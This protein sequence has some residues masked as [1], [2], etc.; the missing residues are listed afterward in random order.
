M[1]SFER[2]IWAF[3]EE[4]LP[5]RCCSPGFA[6]EDD[7]WQCKQGPAWQVVDEIPDLAQPH[8]FSVCDG[9]C[10]NPTHNKSNLQLAYA[11]FNGVGWGDL[12]QMWMD[13]E[14]ATLSD[15][16]RTRRDAEAEAKRQEEERQSELE[17]QSRIITNK[18][19]DHAIWAGCKD[20]KGKTMAIPCKFLYDCQKDGKTGCSRP[21]SLSVVSGTK[22]ECWSYC[23]TCPETGKTIRPTLPDGSPVCRALHPGQPGWLKEWDTNRNFRPAESRPAAPN[24]RFAGLGAPQP[25]RAFHTHTHTNNTNTK[26]NTNYIA[27]PA[28]TKPKTNHNTFAFLNEDSD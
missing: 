20:H 12:D 15:A 22:G 26:P 13:E 2:P 19:R 1:T 5:C 11:E 14:L 10:G 4:E 17:H 28:A 25:Q 8:D 7:L 3:S 9:S 27:K 21:T 16:E 18:V 24:N 6:M 23:Y